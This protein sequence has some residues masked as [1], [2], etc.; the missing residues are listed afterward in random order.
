MGPG[1]GP[2]VGALV[3]LILNVQMLVLLLKIEVDAPAACGGAR[4][5]DH[6]FPSGDPAA[7]LSVGVTG[8]L[9]MPIAVTSSAASSTAKLGYAP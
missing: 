9:R 7:V 1:H 8:S 6:S 4:Q 2:V 3:M 5:M